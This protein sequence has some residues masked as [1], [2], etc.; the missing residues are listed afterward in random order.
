MI[1]H[2]EAKA[3]CVRLTES[4]GSR[5][6]L[7]AEQIIGVSENSRGGAFTLLLNSCEK[8]L[9]LQGVDFDKFMSI[10]EEAWRQ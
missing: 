2:I 10:W 8:I 6:A 7:R 4:N 9:T 5:S 3:G 1:V